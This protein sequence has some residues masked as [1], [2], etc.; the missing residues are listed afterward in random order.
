MSDYSTTGTSYTYK[1]LADW[2]VNGLAA[3]PRR[4][5]PG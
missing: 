3:V 1:A 5:Q 4:L 2:S